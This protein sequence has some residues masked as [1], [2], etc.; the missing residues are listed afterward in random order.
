MSIGGSPDHE[1]A[2]DDQPAIESLRLHRRLTRQMDRKAIRK[3]KTT[4]DQVKIHGI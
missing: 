3:S 1:Q 4:L 2:I